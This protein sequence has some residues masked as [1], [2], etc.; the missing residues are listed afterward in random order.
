M[1]FNVYI[2]ASKRNGTLYVGMTDDLSRARVEVPDRRVSRIHQDV[3]SE[4]AGV[5]GGT[6]D[7][8]V[9]TS[10]ASGR[11]RNGSSSSSRN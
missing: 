1:S 10:L 2:L 9:G 3:R 5:V 7:A 4:D 11:S 6:R 8:G